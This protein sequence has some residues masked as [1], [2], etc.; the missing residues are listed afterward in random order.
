LGPIRLKI[1]RILGA[2]LN[3][4]FP[5]DQ[6]KQ[7]LETGAIGAAFDVLS[8]FPNS[9]I[10]HFLVV[11]TL[12]KMLLLKGIDDAVAECVRKSYLPNRIIRYFE[13]EAH[14]TEVGA[15][16]LQVIQKLQDASVT[17]DKLKA[18]LFKNEGWAKVV[19]R[20]EQERASL[21]QWMEFDPEV[22][23]LKKMKAEGTAPSA[24]NLVVD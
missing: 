4:A 8:K 21:K 2:A 11:D 23:L 1:L 3:P 6:Q 22:N 14:T 17:N 13:D 9:N 19:A 24:K 7:L 12:Q 20:M 16:Y 10:L 15:H 18:V 5:I